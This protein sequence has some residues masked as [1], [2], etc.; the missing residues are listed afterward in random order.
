M[1]PTR[2]SLPLTLAILSMPTPLVAQWLPGAEVPLVVAATHERQRRDSDPKL[3]GWQALATGVVRFA[4]VM[5]QGGKPIERVVRLDELK[6]EVYGQAPSLSKQRIISWRDTNFYPNKLYYHRDHLGIVAHDFGAVIR[7]GEGDE[8]RGV[9]HPLSTAGLALYRFRVRDTV[10]IATATTTLRVVA[11]DVRP[12][13]PR[14]AAAVG[15]LYIDADRGALVRFRFTFTGS[16]YRDATVSG[17]TVELENS[18]I[19]RVAWLPWRQSIVI[20]RADS[21]FGLPIGSALRADWE[22]GDYRFGLHRASQFF[23]GRAITGL[24]QPDGSLTAEELAGLDGTQRLGEDDI[25]AFTAVASRMVQGQLD[26]LPRLRLL[27]AGGVSTFVRA[28]RV[29]GV[30]PGFG[31]ALRPSA[32][33]TI[34]LAAGVGTS[35]G[36]VSGSAALRRQLRA[37]HLSLEVG[38][39]LVDV[40]DTPRISG[41]LNTI[42]TVVDGADLGDWWL[43]EWVKAGWEHRVAGSTLGASVALERNL[44]VRSRFTALDGTRRPNPGLGFGDAVVARLG[45]G[46][47]SPSSLG[48][49]VDV[50]F[51]RGDAD[52]SRARADFGLELP[53]GFVSHLSGGVATSGVP[54]ARSFV[55]GGRGSLPGIA[56]R[57]IGG[58]RF[59]LLDL[60]RPIKLGVGMPG[61]PWHGALDLISRV[62]PF[63]AL[64]SAGGAVAG[65]PWS[66]ID[67][68]EA[69]L[70]LRIDLASSTARLSLGWHPGGDRIYL[71][72]DAHPDWWPIL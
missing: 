21:R 36:M 51:G 72:F 47:L 53:L 29:E 27:G 37:S 3:G 39:G 71:G 66:P 11:V 1:K 54:A 57:S 15:T 56:D 6:V 41:L 59:F 32:L 10:T 9:A 40:G 23:S 63:V 26:G 67:S 28:N 16:S 30:R 34:D 35:D 70:G 58:R 13:D 25:R 4:L 7:L 22:I 31:V 48:G 19:D 60:S 43:R 45:W 61:S 64:G 33:T 17:I 14:I 8:V 18:L 46:K 62:T 24:T 69:V 50:E 68:P 52:W 49:R 44:S 65:A 2:A 12:A 20:R 5:G 42:R 38:R 55:I